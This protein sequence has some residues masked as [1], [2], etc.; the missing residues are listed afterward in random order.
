MRRLY[1]VSQ[2][3]TPIVLS[4]G[5]KRE[6]ISV[7]QSDILPARVGFRARL[8]LALS[9]GLSYRD[10]VRHFQTQPATIALWK[11]RFLQQGV[12]GLVEG[13]RP[14]RPAQRA[15]P[16]AGVGLL[17]QNS[18]DPVRLMTCRELATAAGVSKSTAHRMLARAQGQFLNLARFPLPPLPSADETADLAGLYLR[19]NQQLAVFFVWNG[20]RFTGEG[21]RRMERSGQ[22]ILKA[23][24]ALESGAY[25]WPT[26]AE[27][28]NEN[29]LGFLARVLRKSTRAKSAV[30][31]ACD[32]SIRRNQE[33]QEAIGAY[34]RVKLHFLPTAASWLESLDHWSGCALPA[35][36][37][38]PARLRPILRAFLG[39]GRSLSWVCDTFQ[40]RGGVNSRL[41]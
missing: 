19:S 8:I 30:I 26:A 4:R 38:P 16:D 27:Q 23:L 18:G 32:L 1:F 9:K 33:L 10:I 37:L 25:T 29:Y 24:E 31:L 13:L 17:R 2:P 11:S 39:G 40:N 3:S 21:S 5:Q 22:G 34:V 15:K 14:E 7:S 28:E 6:L 41:F 12:R 20:R 35:A 36:G